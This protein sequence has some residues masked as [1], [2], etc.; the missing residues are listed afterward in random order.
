MDKFAEVNRE[1][2][3]P[4]GNW[5]DS[6]STSTSL[7]GDCEDEICLYIPSGTSSS[8]SGSED[9]TCP[10]K[11]RRKIPLDSSQPSTSNTLVRKRRCNLP[12]EAIKIMKRWLC[13]NKY[14]AY[15]SDSDKLM[16]ARVTGLTVL[17]V[18]NWFINARRRILPELIRREGNDPSYYTIT[19]RGK[20]MSL[21]ANNGWHKYESRDRVGRPESDLT[22][23][24]RREF[25]LTETDEE[26]YAWSCFYRKNQVPKSNFAPSVPKVIV[27]CIPQLSVAE[28]ATIRENGVLV[29]TEVAQNNVIEKEEN[30]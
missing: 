29:E 7:Y 14:N 11:R 6:S 15:P 20:R 21:A 27:E 23:E 8:D 13:D 4:G 3:E 17:Q 12:K 26:D 28:L 30:K 22:E 19:H 16:I 2:K 5:S 25:Q 1:N 9:E 18:C 10:K 24:E